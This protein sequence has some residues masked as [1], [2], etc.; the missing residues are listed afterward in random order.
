M[1]KIILTMCC[2]ALI[3]QSCKKVLEEDIVS[4]I[5][6]EYY[7]SAAGF[8]DAVKASYEPLR[9]HY[10]TQ[11]GFTL[12]VFG[13]DTYTKGAD[14]GF[15]HINDYTS[16]FNSQDSY[17][18][19]LW[20]DFYR[21]INTTNTVIDRAP[22]ADVPAA[23]K[24][25][26]V[27][28]ARFLRAHYYFI[29][30]QTYGPIH[31]SLKETTEIQTTATRSPVKAVYDVIVA[32]LELAITGLPA[33]QNDYGRA[34]KAAAE[35]MLSKVLLTRASIPSAAKADD[36][37]RAA[38]LAKSVIANYGL[39]L[40]PVFAD[41]FDQAKQEHSEVVFAVQY[42]NDLLTNGGGNS[43]HLYFI[44]EYDA[45][46]KGTQRDIA[47]GRPFKRFKPTMYTLDLFDRT[48]D[49]RYNGSFKQVFFANNAATLA[50]GMKLGDTAI[51]VAPVNVSAAV[52][53]SK[54]YRTIDRAEVLSS[55][56]YRYFP[57]LSKFL[58][59][60]RPSV[61]EER[62]SRDYM[63]ARLAETY[64]IAAEALFKSGNTTEA[65]TFINEVRKRAALP[66]KELAMQITASE[67]TMDFILDER[68]RELLGEMDRWFDLVRTG[69]LVDRVKKHNPD[70]AP[71]IQPFHI[72][73]PI[74]SDQIDRTEGGV[75]NFPQN[76][77]Y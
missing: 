32:D 36:Y 59:P 61:Q 8:E 23:L 1:K 29:L 14:G 30:V 11:R 66:G 63:V 13:T 69:T 77:G 44:M 34:S 21:A 6:P 47:N 17:I 28:E 55:G 42:T 39:K 60:L 15:K 74:P 40:L 70:A 33:K 48:K 45:G 35:H 50:T 38:V 67:L 53:A 52:K 68:G 2:L 71:N 57:T 64:L 73:R 75:T 41:V 26:R 51:Y 72:L 4:N 10:G 24:A 18:R 7:K 31:L 49:S 76:T 19:D 65:L 56:N 9:S 25:Q 54:N 43:G 22:T 20:N 27:A 5:T 3:S 62:G 16:G 37:Q 58:D 46:H 12:T